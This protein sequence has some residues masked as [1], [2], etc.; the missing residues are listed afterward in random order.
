MTRSRPSPDRYDAAMVQ[1][2]SS[3]GKWAQAS[4]ASGL[5][6]EHM[7]PR[8]VVVIKTMISGGHLTAGT[9]QHLSRLTVEELRAAL[10]E[11]HR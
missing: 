3:V 8:V 9:S 6:F 4:K 1:A 10:D 5:P 7:P 2:T 11:A